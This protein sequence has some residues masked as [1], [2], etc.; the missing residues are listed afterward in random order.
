M[1]KKDTRLFNPVRVRGG[2]KLKTV[3]TAV[4]AAVLVFLV[5]GTVYVSKNGTAE[6]KNVIKKISTVFEFSKKD[7]NNGKSFVNARTNILLMSV[8][9]EKTEESGEKEIY[10]MAIAHADASTGQIK[11]CPLKVKRE[12][13]KYY[14]DGGPDAVTKAVAKEYKIKMEKYLSLI[15]I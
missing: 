2:N 13:L 7:K 10:F 15:H 4:I 8:S 11:F 9:S 3:L 12:Y 1:N 5:A 14:E 6:A